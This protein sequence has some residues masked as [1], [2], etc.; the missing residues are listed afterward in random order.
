MGIKVKYPKLKMVPLASDGTQTVPMKATTPYHI[1]IAAIQEWYKIIFSK[2]FKFF[3]VET[4]YKNVYKFHFLLSREKIPRKF[5][6]K[7]RI[8]LPR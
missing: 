4:K 6:S 7:F 1:T 3:R 2:T 5:P 8:K